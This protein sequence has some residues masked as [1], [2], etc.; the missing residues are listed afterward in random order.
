MQNKKQK[1]ILVSMLWLTLSSP[2]MADGFTFGV[3]ADYSTGKYGGSQST[4]VTYVPFSAQYNS[5]A[6]T[7]KLTVPWISVTGPG[8]VIPGG[9]GGAS[10]ASSGTTG[11]FGCAADNRK[12]ASKP[13]DNGPC[14]GTTTSTT[15]TGSSG[16]RRITTESGLGDI[17]AAVTYNVVDSETTGFTLDVTG[18]IKFA[19]ASES[20]KLGSGEND[21]AVQAYMEKSFGAPFLSFGLGYKWLGEPSGVSYNHVKYGSFGGGYKFS[22]VTSI[23]ISYDWATSAVDGGTNPREISIYG[24]HSFNQNYKLNAVIYSGLSDASSD[25]GGGLTLTYNW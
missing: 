16:Q 17:V 6:L 3:G 14:A 2:V 15:T 13:E 18:R 24:S 7:Y 4:D 10:S 9:L 12:G 20:R 5:G 25:V 19:T 21:Y 11:N 1:A 22:N 8:I 23:G